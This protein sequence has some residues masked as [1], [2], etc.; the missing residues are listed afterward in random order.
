M[1]GPVQWIEA[2]MDRVVTSHQGRKL[3]GYLT[4]T[5]FAQSMTRGRG[6]LFDDQLFLA[7]LFNQIG[8]DVSI[9]PPNLARRWRSWYDVGSAK[10]HVPD[11][12]WQEEGTR[13]DRGVEHS[14]RGGWHLSGATVGASPSRVAGASSQS[15][16]HPAGTREGISHVLPQLVSIFPLALPPYALDVRFMMFD[17]EWKPVALRGEAALE[18][19]S[20]LGVRYEMVLQPFFERNGFTNRLA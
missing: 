15:A 9:E 7:N 12:Q 17:E 3:H 14:G 6:V 1:R 18:E 2:S 4:A 13:A 10:L 16:P 20:L 19:G 5:N 11:S 8:S